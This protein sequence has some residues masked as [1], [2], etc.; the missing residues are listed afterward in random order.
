MVKIGVKRLIREEINGSVNCN[1]EKPIQ[2]AV[3]IIA[4][5]KITVVNIF[6]NS[7]R[8]FIKDKDGLIITMV[9]EDKKTTNS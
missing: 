8:N 3:K 1:P 2:I 4:A 7:Y 5:I 6:F 9:I